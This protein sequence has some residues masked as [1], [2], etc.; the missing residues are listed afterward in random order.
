MAKLNEQ[1][2]LT[3]PQLWRLLWCRPQTGRSSYWKIHCW[4][5]QKRRW[6]RPET[7][8]VVILIR[9]AISI[10]TVFSMF[11]SLN[12]RDFNLP[13]SHTSLTP[14]Q[15][16]VILSD[17]S[18]WDHVVSPPLFCCSADR[19]QLSQPTP[20]VTW[21]WLLS[22]YGARPFFRHI[23]YFVFSKNGLCVIT[24]KLSCCLC[25]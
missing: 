22:S 1:R 21:D 8:H 15:N 12:V 17:K 6:H 2:E 24:N 11:V 4:I 23:T 14:F 19:P 7:G 13:S 18:R 10:N 16:I 20:Y 5:Q 3:S 9:S 25:F